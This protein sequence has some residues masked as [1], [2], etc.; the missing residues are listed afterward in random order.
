[1]ISKVYQKYLKD[2]KLVIFLFHGV[3]ENNKN[4]IR[5]YNKK[6][7]LSNQFE[8][9]L[10]GLLREGT[11]VSMDDVINFCNGKK[12]P[13]KPFAITFDDGFQN[14]YRFA[15]PILERLKIPATIYITTNFIEKNLMSWIDRIEWAFEKKKN[16][17]IY[18]PWR[19]KSIKI[20]SVKKKIN[21]LNEIRKKV[22]S[23][24][25]IDPKLLADNIQLQLKL[26]K[27]ISNNTQIDKKLS[28]KEIKTLNSN[29]L[30]TI[31][32]HTHNHSILSYIDQKY[33]KKEISYSLKLLRIKAG[34]STKHFSYPEG[35]KI[36]YNK[37]VIKEL[38]NNGIQCCPTAVHGLN[39][40]GS[41]PFKLK[42][43][44]VI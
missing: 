33:L 36:S 42:R 41:N 31:G 9:I 39:L 26:P 8:K 22:K 5:N 20:S 37:F 13:T 3:I 30:I 6:H 12:I 38:K 14:N 7:I 23:N 24:H 40:V 34:V 28:W 15:L 27:K 25:T 43:I 44:F 10:K 29:P 17:N 1:M 32:G 35:T 18:L 19:S 4:Q 21:I 2:K 11:P 16:F